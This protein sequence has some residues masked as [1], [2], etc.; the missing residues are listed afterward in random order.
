MTDPE[1]GYLLAMS[2]RQAMAA[3]AEQV[4]AAGLHPREFALLRAVAADDPPSQRDVADR[5]GLPPSRV[6]GLVDQLVER[7]LVERAVDPT[8]RRTRRIALTSQGSRAL[9][10]AQARADQ[11]QEAMVQDL[12]PAELATTRRAL[13]QISARLTELGAAAAPVW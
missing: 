10:R 5:L 12:S 4:A 11:M 8:D 9:R 6:V 13:Q 2:G 7:G 3:F 1:L